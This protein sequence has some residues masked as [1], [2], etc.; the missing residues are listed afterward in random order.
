MWNESNMVVEFDG[1]KVQMPSTKAKEKS[2]YVK[3]DQ[4]RYS[5][6]TEDEYK[7]SLI[8]PVKKVIKVEE[9]DNEK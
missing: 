7:K 1:E 6:A 4:N 8:K 2:V 3:F 5:L 9:N